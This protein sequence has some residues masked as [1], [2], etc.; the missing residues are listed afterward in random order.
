M[1][2][3]Y[4]IL[5]IYTLS[6]GIIFIFS[7]GQAYLIY[8]YLK[9]KR[10]E[11]VIPILPLEIPKVT[12]QLPLYNELYVVERLIDAVCKL[13]YPKNCLEIQ[14]LDDSTDNSLQ[15]TQQIVAQKNALGFNIVHITRAKNIGFKA[16][17]LQHGLNLAKGEFIAIFDADFLPETNFLQQLIPYFNQPKIGMVQSRWGH[18]N[19]GYSLLTKVQGFGLDGHFTIEQTGRNHANLFMNFNGT[20]GIWRKTCIQEAGGWQHDTLTEDLDLSYRAQL[21]GWDFQYVEN[22]VTPAELPVESNALRSQ[23]HRWTK[24]AIETSKKMVKEIW[25]TDVSIR[26]KIFGTLH[27]MNSYVFIFV[28]L[29][30]ILSLPVLYIKSQGLIPSIYFQLLSV[31]LLGFIIVSIFYLVASRSKKEKL[32]L[33]TKLFPMFLS[34]SMALSFHNS[35]AVLEGLFGFK[36]DFI[37]TPKFNIIKSKENFKENIYVKRSL[38]KSFYIELFLS[39]YFFLGLYLAFVLQDFALFPFHLML[40]IGFSTLNFYSVKH[41]IVPET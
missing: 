4:I 8:S 31:F 15:I 39:L 16:G 24:G 6:L 17:A 19:E 23:Q 27:L 3:Q 1:I 38:S 18:I 33:F 32:G 2:W 7:L 41:A 22:V 29:T 14:V 28:L 20:A 36:S 11:D 35:I 34:V 25:R 40:F 13:N 5:A 9:S 10:K 30:S 12:V 21:K 37:R 26:K